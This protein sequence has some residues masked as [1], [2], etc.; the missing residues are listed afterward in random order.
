MTI[1]KMYHKEGR[2]GR[3]A[4]ENG[5]DGANGKNCARTTNIRGE[6]IE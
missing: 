2:Y 1:S 6:I 4:G 5:K 3:L